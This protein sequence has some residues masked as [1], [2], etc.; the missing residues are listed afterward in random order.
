LI[1]KPSTPT[2]G[3]QAITVTASPDKAKPKK[4][5]KALI[6]KEP[7]TTADSGP[8]GVNSINGLPLDLPLLPTPTSASRKRKSTGD[9]AK[10][11]PKSKP[12][13][14]NGTPKSSDL[15]DIKGTSCHFI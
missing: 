14:V 1:P 11:P 10:S 7:G 5:K 12:E 15:G 9:K 8:S 4:P 13:N 2:V 3:V 6:K